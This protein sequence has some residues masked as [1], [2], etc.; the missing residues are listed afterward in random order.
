M[1]LK[2]ALPPPPSH[3][4]LRVRFSLPL[5]GSVRITRTFDPITLNRTV[6]EGLAD[7]VR[8]ALG[9]PSSSGGGST[10]SGG[11]R[12]SSFRGPSQLLLPHSSAP[13]GVSTN[14]TFVV[15]SAPV[16][17]PNVFPQLLRLPGTI[18]ATVPAVGTAVRS[19]ALQLMA[20]GPAN[21][22]DG[23]NASAAATAAGQG[24][25]ASEAA[26]YSSVPLWWAVTT[27]LPLTA[28]DYA[29]G[30]QAALGGQQPAGLYFD[31]VSDNV[32]PPLLVSA[33]GSSYSVLAIYVTVVLAGEFDDG[34]GG[35]G[36]T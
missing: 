35:A 30:S 31:T 3:C 18:S 4:C 9:I 26:A 25:G 1:R 36:N 32:A 29:T 19:V 13:P 21:A 5:A 28:S 7:Q 33:L 6:C 23:G 15:F 11:G 12:P 27:A 24:S 16:V 20:A 8:A 17:V 10:S 2:P 14:A 34:R 22:T